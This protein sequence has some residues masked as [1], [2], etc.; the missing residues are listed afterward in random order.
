MAQV[1]HVCGLARPE[2]S[3]RALKSGTWGR[4]LLSNRQESGPKRW[5]PPHT[6]IPHS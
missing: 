4:L 2:I 5:A 1:L 3:N 6:G